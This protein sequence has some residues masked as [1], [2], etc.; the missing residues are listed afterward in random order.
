LS[1]L[2]AG[3]LGALLV[4][5][6]GLL[7]EEWRSDREQVALLRL[8][9]AEVEH[10]V[11]VVQTL[12]HWRG[13]DP[14]IDMRLMP[15]IKSEVWHDVRVRAAQLLPEELTTVLNDYYSPLDNVLT[16]RELQEDRK[17]LDLSSHVLMEA[18]GR[19]AKQYEGPPI[20]SVDYALLTLQAQT[21]TRNKL[22]DQLAL[23]WWKRY[24][25][26]GRV[27]DWMAL[28]LRSRKVD[29]G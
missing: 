3:L 11:A 24:P 10:N 1:V 25:L 26:T 15:I 16:I 19:L 23:P 9:L 5:V 2:F 7:R 28:A 22:A 12:E 17:K 4:F 27:V 6:L 29:R 21:A 20:L 13:S 8:L 18:I 14:P